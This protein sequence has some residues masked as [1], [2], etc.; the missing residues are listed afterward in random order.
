MEP[1]AFAMK[2]IAPLALETWAPTA[3]ESLVT[4]PAAAGGIGRS[5]GPPGLEPPIATLIWRAVALVA[6]QSRK[7]AAQSA[8]FALAA[9]PYVSGEDMAASGPPA[10]AEGNAKNPTL[11]AAFLS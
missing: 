8:F 1:V 4:A 11:P 6:T 9:M 3:S 5:A 2:S 7:K 10:V